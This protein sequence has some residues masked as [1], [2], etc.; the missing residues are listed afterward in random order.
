MRPFRT[1]PWLDPETTRKN[2]T[3]ARCVVCMTHSGEIRGMLIDTLHEYGF[4]TNLFDTPDQCL[5][6]LRTCQS[7]LLL[8]DCDGDTSS[9][10]ELLAQSQQLVRQPPAVLLVQRGDVWTAVRA[11]QT[12][13]A[14]C[15]EK[16]IEMTRLISTL[17]TVLQ[18]TRFKYPGGGAAL[19]DAEA[20]VLH[21]ILQ[22]K[23]SREI[24]GLLCRSHRTVEV[25]RHHIMRKLGATTVVGLVKKTASLGSAWHPETEREELT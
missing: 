24:A 15:V 17:R 12:G 11:I 13:A 23:T 1:C 20:T 19:T 10:L 25:H 5:R 16:P 8:I 4:S 7:D 14:D 3:S 21:H 18:Q 2:N 22:G 9:A 6:L